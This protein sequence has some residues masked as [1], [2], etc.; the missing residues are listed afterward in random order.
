M[1]GTSGPTLPT[2][3]AY[4]DPDGSSW[5]TSQGTLL[6]EDQPL[7]ERLPNWGM[8]QDSVLYELPMPERLTNAND[9]SLFPTPTA[10]QGRSLTS[11]MATGD[12]RKPGSTGSLGLTLNDLAFLQN[13][14]D[15]GKPLPGGKKLLADPPPPLLNETE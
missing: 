2:P 4:L 15:T 14:K 11:G 3:L 8:T 6:S 13:L 1:N 12:G 7:L 5:R 10:E 9:F